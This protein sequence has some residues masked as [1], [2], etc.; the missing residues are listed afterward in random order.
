MTRQLLVTS[1]LP[2]ANGPI[3]LGHLVEYIQTDVFARFQRLRGH[4]VAYLCADDTHGTAIMIRAQ[5]EGRTPE[6]LIAD[7]AV[8]HQRDFAAF[9]VSFDHYGSTNSPANYAICSGIWSNLRAANMVVERSVERLYDPVQQTFLADRFVIGTCP[10]CG[11]ADQYGDSCESCGST[12]AATELKQPRSVHSGATPELRPSRQLFVRL[13]SLQPFLTEWTQRS[14]ALQQEVANYLAGHFLDKPLQDWDVSRPAPYFGF[15]IP[16]AKGQF[17]YVWFDAPVG[18]IASTAEWC[19]RTGQS[20]DSWW[21]NERCEIVHFLGKD[22]TYFHTLFWPALLHVGGYRLPSR[23]QIH[24]FLRVAGEKMSKS[25][26]T[27][28]TA[29]K[30]LEAGLDPEW[31]RYYYASKLSSKIDDLDFQVDEFTGKVNSD[32]VGRVVNLASRSARFVESCGLSASYPDDGGLFARAAAQREAIAAAYEACD[33]RDAMRLVMTLAD[34]ANEYVEQKAPWTIKKDPSRARELQDV[35][36]VVL[37]LFHQIAIYLQPVLPKLA[38]KAGALLGTGCD[39]WELVTAPLVGTKVAKFEHMMQRIER[40]KVQ[41]MFVPEASVPAPTIPAAPTPAARPAA[42]AAATG[43]TT[44]QK[45]PLAAE[46]TIEDFQK[47]DL[48]IAEVVAAEAVPE[49]KKL[50]RLTLSLGAGQTRNVFAGIKGAYEPE[51]LVGRLVVMVANLAPR[52]MKFGLSEGMVIAAGTD[53]E[54]FLLSPDAGARPGHR[55]H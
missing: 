20:L 44:L 3:H 8:Q 34:A 47:V 10:R 27:F 7:M 17:W 46:I 55:L 23:V 2:Y 24:G 21:K 52:K 12:Y 36:T 42:P 53:G 33:Y 15:E 19:Q 4:R 49:A 22:I 13:E 5:K 48:R 1:A 31:L 29:A 6:Q 39:R 40:D 26:G 43:E 41:A 30:Y 45:E 25:K 38:A 14:G 11:A 37:N 35:C 50:L 51:Q 16:D 28:V 9:G 54:V 32:L 18:Y